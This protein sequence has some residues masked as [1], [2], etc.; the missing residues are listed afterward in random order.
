MLGSRKGQLLEL[1]D[2]IN[3]IGLAIKRID[4]RRPQAS[5]VRTGIK[6]Q[7]GIGPH[8]ETQ[9]VSLVAAELAVLNPIRYAD[10]LQTGVLN[11]NRR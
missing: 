2:L 10:R 8:P 3:D 4:E 5:N 9:A 11:C 7:P 6:Y 1:A